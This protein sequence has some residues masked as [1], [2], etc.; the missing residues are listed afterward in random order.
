MKR[1]DLQT[2]GVTL[3]ASLLVWMAAASVGLLVGSTGTIGAPTADQMS[4]RLHTHVL[5]A[6]MIG[7]AL[8]MAGVTYQAILRN[9]LADPYLLGASGGAMLASYVWR[10]Q[11]VASIAVIGAIS[12]HAFALAGSLLAI[13]IVL[14]GAGWR[15][16]LDPVTA[17]LVGV[18]INSLCGALFMLLN[19]IYRDLPGSGGILT[20][21]VG[22]IQTTASS[23]HVAASAWMI[24]IGG[25]LLMLMTPYLNVVR[26]SEDEARS[27]GVSVQRVRWGG[28]LVASFVTAAAVAISGPIGFIGLICPHIARWF[29]GNDNRKLL[30][31]A[32]ALGAGLLTLADVLARYLLGSPHVATLIPVGVITACIGGPFLLLILA[33]IKQ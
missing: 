5:P 3:F 17:I 9:P 28:L 14:L 27:L 18:V 6:S 16:R 13:T 11:G 8:A 1:F 2:L 20:F 4:I 31:V 24:G 23:A 26:L 15:G 12:P 33:R 32:A 22:D 10:L 30:P 21:L 7:A 25:V 29:I 19:A